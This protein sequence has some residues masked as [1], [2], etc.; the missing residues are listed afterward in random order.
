MATIRALIVDDEPIARRGI[1]LHLASFPQVEI[2]GE[3]CNGLEA[4]AEIQEHAPD[5]VFLDV[6][7]PEMDGFE[8]IQTV[9]VEQMPAVI[10]VTA[11]DAYAIRA[12]DVHAVD[13]LLKPFDGDRFRQAL[14]HARSNIE[15]RVPLN[16]GEQLRAVLEEHL[17]GRKHLERSVVKSAGRIF[18]LYVAEID[19]MEAADNY[20]ELHV[21]K[22]CHLVR[23]T[24][25]S[26]EARL[27]P[28]RF[29][30]IRHS[31]IV[32]LSQVKELRPSSGGE[33]HVV[34]HSRIERRRLM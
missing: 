31:T 16:V 2:V 32:N 12:F 33:Y 28:Q 14:E 29:V 8:V 13:Y 6:Q 4:V 17:A 23:Q 3:C 34:L 19:W 18:F 10:F 30:R 7:M 20:A 15:R 24:L 27:D 9:G 5:L 1:R 22:Q 11:Y 25:G 21:G 26:L